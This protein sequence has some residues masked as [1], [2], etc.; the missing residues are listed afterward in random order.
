MGVQF[1]GLAGFLEVQFHGEASF[2]N[3]LFHGEAR[4]AGAQFHGEVSFWN[5][6]FYGDVGFGG[7]QFHGTARFTGSRFHGEAVFLGVQFGGLAGFWDARFH[8]KARFEAAQL[9]GQGK[10]RQRELRTQRLSPVPYLV[11]KRISL[12]SSRTAPSTSPARN[13]RRCPPSI[14][15][16]SN[17][18]RTSTMCASQTGP[19]GAVATKTSFL[20]IAH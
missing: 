3:A 7:A 15:R 16:I 5:A 14:R 13:S 10:L 2:W 20:N 19:S 6:S 8:E 12:P 1:N 11:A 18:H 9:K 17:K 4:F